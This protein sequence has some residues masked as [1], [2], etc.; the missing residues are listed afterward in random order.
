M[1]RPAHQPTLETNRLRLRPFSLADAPTV[2]ALAG[3]VEVASTTLTIP[4][5][6]EDGMAES[7][8]ATHEPGY[9]TG[10][11]ATFA[12]VLKET[13]EL[14]GAIGLTINASHRR[15]EMGYWVG[16]PFWNHGYATEAADA[17]LA[18][19][20]DLLELHRIHAVHLSRNPASGRVMQKAGMRHESTQ[21]QHIL[22]RGVFEDVEGYGLLAADRPD[23]PD[24]M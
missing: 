14:I 17:L 7:W 6:Y 19:G 16:V 15:G 8:I 3:A 22:K 5:P 4:H 10:E 21:R 9:D 24:S 1:T 20:F 23:E 13:G 11:Q 12:I 2:Q 18:F